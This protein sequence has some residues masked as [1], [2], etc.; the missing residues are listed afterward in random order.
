MAA[1]NSNVYSW[2]NVLV[3]INEH[4]CS[5]FAK[6]D[7]AIKI[8]PM[9]NDAELVEGLDA[10]G[11]FNINPSTAVTIELK[12]LSG[13]PTDRYLT[14]QRAAMKRGVYRGMAV[15]VIESGSGEGGSASC[16]VIQ[17]APEKTYGEKATE[18]T[19]TIV[20]DNWVDNVF[21]FTV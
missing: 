14:T 13:S 6:A 2:K 15:T 4:Q 7:D 8:A 10:Y 1:C 17:K 12:L 9:N 16:A 11:V 3:T 5:G 18:R 19:W 20:A 21:N